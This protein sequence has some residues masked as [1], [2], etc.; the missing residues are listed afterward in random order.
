MKTLVV[1]G[2]IGSGKSVVCE[3]LA[4]KGIPVYDSDLRAKRLYEVRPAIIGELEESLGGS[5][6]LQ[7]GSL[8]R[9]ALAA[10]VFGDTEKLL[11]LEGIVHPYVVNDFLEWRNSYFNLVPFVVL[12]SA[13]YF[14]KPLFHPLADRVLMVDAPLELRI[15]RVARRDSSSREEILARINAQDADTSKA[16]AVVVNDGN[17][18]DLY[19][20]VETVLSTIWNA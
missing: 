18:V 16:D 10:V 6:R 11:I 12:E 7:D 2:G 20:K 9:R 17:I 5:F 19:E 8:D 13:I 1:T 3:Y 15:S 14:Q 4:G